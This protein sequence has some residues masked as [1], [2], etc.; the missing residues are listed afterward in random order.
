[1]MK[2]PGYRNRSEALR[3]LARAG[4]RQ[5]NEGASDAQDCI[6]A[7]VYVYDHEAREVSKRSP[8]PSTIITICR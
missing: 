5:A 7:L 4:M 1:M 3:D 6:A 2:A 8:A